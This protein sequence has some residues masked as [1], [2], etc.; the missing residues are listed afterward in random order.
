MSPECL[1]LRPTFP[2]TENAA[3]LIQCVKGAA[4]IAPDSP[5]PPTEA[6]PADTIGDVAKPDVSPEPEPE[7]PV[8]TDKIE[9]AEVSLPNA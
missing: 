5:T 4:V 6:D 8:N 2:G 7:P 3:T 9:E 1:A